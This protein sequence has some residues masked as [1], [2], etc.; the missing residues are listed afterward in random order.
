VPTRQGDFDL[1][2]DASAAASE[3]TGVVD[4]V[5]EVFERERLAERFAGAWNESNVSS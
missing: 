5:V 1:L 3:N 4:F 2:R